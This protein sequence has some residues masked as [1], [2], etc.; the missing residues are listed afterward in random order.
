MYWAEKSGLRRELRAAE[1]EGFH[2]I[3]QHRG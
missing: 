2:S 3:R 1:I